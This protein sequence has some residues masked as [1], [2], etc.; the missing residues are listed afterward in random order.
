MRRARS[1]QVLC[2]FYFF[3]FSE[4]RLNEPP[5]A[6]GFGH[7]YFAKLRKL[8]LLSNFMANWVEGGG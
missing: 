6:S 8:Q 5:N 4:M 7:F 3:L 1:I 2:F